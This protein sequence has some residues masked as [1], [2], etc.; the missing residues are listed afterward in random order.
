MAGALEAGFGSMPEVEDAEKPTSYYVPKHPWHA[1][2]SYYP[3][4]PAAWNRDVGMWG[5]CDVDVLFYVFYYLPGGYMQ[6]V[7]PIVYQLPHCG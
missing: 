5:L 6:C 1:T 3:R 2:P 7:R 4:E